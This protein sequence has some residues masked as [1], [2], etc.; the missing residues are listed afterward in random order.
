MMVVTGPDGDGLVGLLWQDTKP[1][2]TAE[3]AINARWRRDLVHISLVLRTDCICR[4]DL[5]HDGARFDRVFIPDVVHVAT[6]GIDE[7]HSP[8]ISVRRALAIVGTD[9]TE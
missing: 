2:T 9:V 4:N 8:R 5:H 6:A 1:R 7:P 3:A